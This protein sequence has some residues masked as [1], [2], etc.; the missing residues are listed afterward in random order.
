M[1]TRPQNSITARIKTFLLLLILLFFFSGVYSQ[2]ANTDSLSKL[3]SVEKIDSNR[4]RLMWQLARDMGVYNPDT[5]LVLSQQA[6]YLARNIHYLEGESRAIGI[7]A[8]TFTKIGNYPK[9]LELNIQKLQLEEKRD[10]PRNLVSVL[11]NIGVVYVLQ[12]EYHKALDYYSKADSVI[13]RY[14]VEDMEYFIA[15]NIGDVYN[16]LNI[17]DSAFTYFKKSL[18]LAKK[19]NDGDLTGTSMTGLGHSYLKMGNHLQSLYYY[20]TAIGLLKIANDDEILCEATL[21]IASLYKKMN[22]YDSASY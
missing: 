4:V 22:R 16:R 12:E 21:G 9:A 10:K 13:R 19:L 17:S 5:A 14:N 6:L 3:L 18:E 11:M 15:L 8:N 7:M 20:Q 1:T 2:K